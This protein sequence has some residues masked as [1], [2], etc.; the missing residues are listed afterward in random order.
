MTNSQ[1]GL[2]ALVAASA[3]LW[4]GD[5]AL[6]GLASVVQFCWLKLR[7]RAKIPKLSVDSF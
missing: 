5:F 7:H 1:F 3:A 6:K 4:L 2:N